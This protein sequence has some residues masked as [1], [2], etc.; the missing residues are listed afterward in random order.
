MSLPT[1]A[2]A[3]INVFTKPVT[4]PDWQS[5]PK[6]TFKQF[7]QG[8]KRQNKYVLITIYYKVVRGVCYNYIRNKYKEYINCGYS[9][10]VLLEE[11]QNKYGVEP[12]ITCLMCDI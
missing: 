5:N 12:H 2:L 6:F 3:L 11:I 9:I 8:I 7:F 4:R 1:R 10:Q